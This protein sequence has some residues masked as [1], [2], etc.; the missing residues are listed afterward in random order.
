MYP[1]ARLLQDI[2]KSPSN[3]LILEIYIPLRMNDA[4]IRPIDFH[5]IDES[6]FKNFFRCLAV[7]AVLF[8]NGSIFTREAMDFFLRRGVPFNLLNFLFLVKVIRVFLL[9]N[10]NGER[11]LSCYLRHI[12]IPF[13]T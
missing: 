6:V 10:M 9:G 4:N 8:H 12:W 7:S 11:A 1:T 3:N 5:E 13:S 2:L